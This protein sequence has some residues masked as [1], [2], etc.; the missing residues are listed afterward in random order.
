MDVTGP[1]LTAGEIYT[2]K[3]HVPKDA[4]DAKS[5]LDYWSQ[6]GCTSYRAY[7]DAPRG[8]EPR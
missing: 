2:V 7:M 6:E 8:F 5:T 1:Y 4:E 3:M